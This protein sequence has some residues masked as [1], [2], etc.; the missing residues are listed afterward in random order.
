M[1]HAQRSWLRLPDPQFLWFSEKYKLRESQNVLNLGNLEYDCEQYSWS[2]LRN[3]KDKITCEDAQFLLDTFFAV[4]S[5]FFS[6]FGSPMYLHVIQHH[7]LDQLRTENFLA[8]LSNQGFEKH[9]GTDKRI[10]NQATLKNGCDSDIVFDIMQFH[11]MKY[12]LRFELFSEMEIALKEWHVTRKDFTRY[13]RIFGPLSK[14]LKIR[15]S[16][17]RYLFLKKQLGLQD[18]KFN[19]EDEDDE[20]EDQTS[21]KSPDFLVEKIIPLFTQDNQ[22]TAPLQEYFLED[23]ERISSLLF[24]IF[25]TKEFFLFW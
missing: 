8:I 25:L 5:L 16:Q 12:L 19:N 10:Y 21:N 24:L 6:D 11:F 22:E 20:I 4:I 14:N 15:S 1:L 18:L 13:T 23:L 17:H 9:H 2:R 7:L 3:C